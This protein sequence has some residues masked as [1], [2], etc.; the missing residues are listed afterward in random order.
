MLKQLAPR[1][2]VIT[3]GGIRRRLVYQKLHNDCGVQENQRTSITEFKFSSDM[4]EF[5]VIIALRGSVRYT[6]III[7]Q[8]K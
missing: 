8:T 6:N 2:L 4:V 1:Y 7:Q 5:R 3:N